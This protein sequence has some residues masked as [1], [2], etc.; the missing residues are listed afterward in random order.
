M[1]DSFCSQRGSIYTN[2]LDAG[3]ANTAFFIQ[4][5]ISIDSLKKEIQQLIITGLDAQEGLTLACLWDLPIQPVSSG[6]NL[7]CI[8]NKK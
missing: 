5:K 3:K 7:A 1:M 2:L 6:L 8:W 4:E